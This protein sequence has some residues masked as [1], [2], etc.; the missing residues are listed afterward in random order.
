M[1]LGPAHHTSSTYGT[2][3]SEMIGCFHTTCAAIR[4]IL[5][6]KTDVSLFWVLI[7]DND[8]HDNL[9]E[10]MEED[11]EDDWGSDEEESIVKEEMV[12]KL[13]VEE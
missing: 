11:D 2:L 1:W 5:L 4:N 7:D 10:D 3:H 6:T 9:Q 12:S 8:I 13:R